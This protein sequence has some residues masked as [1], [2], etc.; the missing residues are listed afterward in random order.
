M[1]KSILNKKNIIY[2][3]IN[4]IFIGLL[5]LLDQWT[6]ALTVQ[7]LKGT[8]GFPIIKDVFEL[9]YV[10]NRGVAFGMM[11]NQKGMILTVTIIL[12]LAILFFLHKVK[13]M[14]HGLFGR[15][16]LIMIAAGGIGNMID[17]I[18]NGFVTD[19]FSFVLIHFPVF[20]VADIY[21]VCGTI[22][23]SIYIL[24]FSEDKKDESI[25]QKEN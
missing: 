21:I 12:M 11:Q 13:D 5:I 6:K 16:C 2:H 23:I 20:N 17:R 25:E 4:I 1:N 15:I 22:L 14:P 24:F 18:V 7:K 3:G 8:D 10:E 9:Y 19:L